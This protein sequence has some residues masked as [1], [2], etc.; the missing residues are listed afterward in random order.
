MLHALKE[1]ATLENIAAETGFKPKTVRWLLVFS[2]EGRFLGVQ[3]LA[4][5]GARLGC[6]RGGEEDDTE[7]EGKRGGKLFHC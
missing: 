7:Q 6:G 1:Y 5:H 2:T 4:P 3:D